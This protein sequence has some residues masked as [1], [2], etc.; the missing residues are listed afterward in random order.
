VDGQHQDPSPSLQRLWFRIKERQLLQ[1]RQV[2]GQHQDS[3]QPLQQLW[4]RIE[5]EQLLQVRQVGP[6]INPPLIYSISV[7]QLISLFLTLKKY[8]SIRHLI[9]LY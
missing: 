1:V 6:L 3:R 7:I 2:D 4:L 9:F 8:L 5:E